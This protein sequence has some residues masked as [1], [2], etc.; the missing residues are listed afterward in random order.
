MTNA[1]PK[2]R[3]NLMLLYGAELLAKLLAM[4]VFAFLGRT[5]GDAGMGGLEFALASWFLL[6]LVMEAG[7]G[8]F[9]ARAAA[10]EPERENELASRVT[11]LR[12]LLL[13]LDL[14][15]L[16][17]LAGVLDRP[18]DDRLLLLAYGV[19]LVPAA[20]DLNWSFQARD[21]MLVV[22]CGSLLRQVVLA[23]C[24]FASV[25]SRADAW[26][27][28]CGD[29][30]G[31][32]LAVVMQHV[33]FGR[34]GGQ[35]RPHRAWRGA[36][37][38]A[39]ESFPLALSSLAWAV[40]IFFPVIAVYLFRPASD[41]GDFGGAH[42][43]FTAAHTFVWL[44]FFNLLPS[45]SRAAHTRDVDAWRAFTHTSIARVAWL[46]GVGA[47]VGTHLAA[48][49]LPAIY[50]PDYHDA[51]PAFAVL[52]WVLAIAFLSGH[53]RFTLIAWKL[54][55]EECLASIAGALVSVVGC[56]VL[57]ADLRPVVAASVLLVAESVTFAVAARAVSS[58][59]SPLRAGRVL[60]RPGLATGSI[61]AL[62]L[63]VA[64]SCGA[65]AA[66]GTTVLGGLL[67]LTF[68]DRD[69]LRRIRGGNSP[70][71]DPLS[72]PDTIVR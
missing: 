56:L 70:E 8:P 60:G 31:L 21:R 11:C 36:L 62:S 29:A 68:L 44:Y 65:F 25:R 52:S 40:R 66:A 26:L 67:A 55:R 69:L 19:V 18:L 24:V 50:G 64:W 54:Q 10:Q 38:M 72:S 27:V 30:L 71:R 41:T 51:A 4:A 53:H 22:A 6:N 48:W 3:R 17:V 23:V 35:L 42:R 59:V 15:L 34:R 5:L 32:G 12:M 2:L 61:A 39:R 57:A 49:L 16:A 14:G 58:R 37:S 63:L 7:L 1:T 47:L 13:V 9:A 43:L 45:L 28:P 46:V 33:L 20:F